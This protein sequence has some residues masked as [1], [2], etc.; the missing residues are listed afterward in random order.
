MSS[1]YAVLPHDDLRQFAT[2]LLRAAGVPAEHAALIGDSLVAANLRGVDSHGVQLILFYLTHIENGNVDVAAKGRIAL[3][4][5]STMVYD[6]QNGLGQVVSAECCDHV[7]RLARTSG[8]GM[9]TARE[10]N[11]FG[12]AA[13]WA[14]R[15]ARAG[16]IGLVMCNATPLVVPWQGKE[17]RF[18][19][20]PI[21]MALPG[22]DIFLLDMAT[23]TV[24]LNKI[25]KA[26]LSGKDRIPEG[27]ALDPDGNPTT[28]PKL[29]LEGTPMPLGGY[30]GSGL[31]MMAEILSAVLS[32]GAMSTEL[33]GIRVQNKPMR[34]GHFFLGIEVERFLPLDEFV[35]RMTRLREMVKNTEP[36]PGYDEVLV[37]GEPEWRA[38]AK[39]RAQ[40]IPLDLEIWKQLRDA[41][42]ARRVAAPEARITSSLE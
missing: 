13:Y 38:E 17:K 30:K 21:C 1:D 8:L 34:V 24:A 11:H 33:G 10:S 4:S 16:L 12:A 18:G 32:G 2:A 7:I 37:A 39:R 41:A 35:A 14:Q 25:Y 27:W 19:T 6:G 28:D 5:G 20:N 31:A 36:A 26:V 15:I 3:E 23:T 9:V 29:A 40:G 22:P 42:A